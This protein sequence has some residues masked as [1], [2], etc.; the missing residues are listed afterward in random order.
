[1]RTN[2]LVSRPVPASCLFVAVCSFCPMRVFWAAIVLSGPDHAPKSTLAALYKLD[3][4][5]IQVF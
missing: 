4:D 5:A 2:A 3:F 1:M